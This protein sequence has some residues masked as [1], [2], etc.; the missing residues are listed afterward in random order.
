MNKRIINNRQELLQSFQETSE[1]FD[2]IKNSIKKRESLIKEF[3]ANTQTTVNKDPLE[4][5]KLP[6]DNALRQA[7]TSSLLTLK[8]QMI[9]WDKSVKN[10]ACNAEFRE[11]YGDSLLVFVYGKVKSGKSSLGNYIAYGISKP[12]SEII[13]STNP[14]PCF[15]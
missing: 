12:T 4:G 1:A 15:F 13:A 5:S 7:I 14:R 3:L 6:Q 11:K 10:Y 2:A 8:D 9:V